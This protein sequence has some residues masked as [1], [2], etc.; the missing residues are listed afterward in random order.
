MTE[1]TKYTVHKVK[2]LINL[3]AAPI[4]VG[5]VAIAFGGPALLVARSW[6]ALE[7]ALSLPFFFLMLAPFAIVFGGLQFVLFGGLAMYFFL[8][9]HPPNIFYAALIG[10]VVNLSI[11]G[12][13]FAFTNP[14]L[15]WDARSYLS[16]CLYFGSV[17]APIWSAV[18]MWLYLKSTTQRTLSSSADKAAA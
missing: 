13:A 12:I 17:F 10:L 9:H 15:D 8:R 14:V 1:K 6:P 7:T 3:I 16:L 11:T 18:A 2:L 4:L 5:L